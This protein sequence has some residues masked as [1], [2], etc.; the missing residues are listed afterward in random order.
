MRKP[1]VVTG[2]DI[3]SSKIAAVMALIGKDGGF[4]IL[5]HATVDSHGVSKGMVTD[6]SSLTES[7]TKALAKLKSGPDRR[8]GEI[9]V[10]VS[11]GDLKGTRSAG[12]VPISLRGREI[13]RSDI[14]KSI[15]AAGT[16]HLPFDREIVHRIVRGFSIDDQ[17]WIKN[18]FG[19]YASRLACEIF[20]ITAN[21]NHIQ[22]IYKCVNDA[23]Y[24]VKE[25][26]FTGVADGMSLLDKNQKE[27]GAILVDMGSSLTEI[28]VFFGGILESFDI[29]DR[30]IAGFDAAI[31]GISK[32]LAE[33]SKKGS[34]SPSVIITGGSAL[35][36][37][38]IEL[39]EEKISCPVK[40]GAVKDTRGRI[41]GIESV[42][43]VTAIGLAEYARDKK[44]SAESGIAVR[45]STRLVEIFNNYF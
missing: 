9:Y 44:A 11:G 12:M 7:V 21:S 42:C 23:G 40:L 27:S 37:G 4:E 28:S 13:T 5:S 15:D 32:R 43:L 2:L 1:S 14:N 22:S 34:A 3:G 45:L 36:D 24:D 25:V 19:L 10:N 8:C 20:V 29:L 41:S 16:I 18:P 30:E 38:M 6:V 17:P 39:I 35:A 33:C 26:V 31:S